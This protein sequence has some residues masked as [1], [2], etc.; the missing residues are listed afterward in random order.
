ME[1]TGLSL[2]TVKLPKY[3][4]KLNKTIAQVR[5]TLTPFFEEACDKAVGVGFFS[6]TGWD[7]INQLPGW[8]LNITYY[9]KHGPTQVCLAQIISDPDHEL[10][11]RLVKNLVEEIS[12]EKFSAREIERLIAELVKYDTTLARWR[13]ITLS[14]SKAK[15]A[16]S[17]AAAEASVASV[18]SEAS[19]VTSEEIKRDLGE[20]L[21][22]L[23]WVTQPELASKITGMILELDDAEIRSLIESPDKLKEKITEALGVLRE[24]HQDESSPSTPTAAS[25]PMTTSVDLAQLKKDLDGL[26]ENFDGLK[27]N[28]NTLQAEKE[29]LHI[30]NGAL[31][32]QLQ[33]HQTDNEALRAQLQAHQ[34]DNEALRAQ[35]QAHQTDNEALRAQLQ[36]LQTD[37]RIKCDNLSADNK[38][39]RDQLAENLQMLRTLHQT[40]PG[41]NPHPPE[42]SGRS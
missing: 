1:E 37:H 26:H 35:L 9:N 30:E 21:Y 18:S 22:P 23:I 6:L 3:P 10:V 19:S 36:A 25:A 34:T 31:Q 27:E 15:E 8:L 20:D 13:E 41:S 11:A 24:Y 40:L 38:T 16:A 29:T 28:F 14:D 5:K 32:A 4:Y 33:A 39:L 2:A 17:V 12:K 42:Q 7:D